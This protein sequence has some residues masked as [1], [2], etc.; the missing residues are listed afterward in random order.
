MYAVLL[1]RCMLR[2]LLLGLFIPYTHTNT[3]TSTIIII[4][5]FSGVIAAFYS[6]FSSSLTSPLSL[7]RV[8]F[9]SLCAFKIHVYRVYMSTKYIGNA[10]TA[11]VAVYVLHTLACVYTILLIFRDRPETI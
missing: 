5:P 1:R 7:D 8:G 2:L 11:H 10:L 6:T 9:Q 4:L 3:L